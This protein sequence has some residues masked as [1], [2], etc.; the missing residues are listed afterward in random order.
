MG[1]LFK[2]KYGEVEWYLISN[3]AGMIQKLRKNHLKTVVK[4]QIFLKKVISDCKIISWELPDG[5]IVNQSY[6]IKEDVTI[7]TSF[8]KREMF[9]K[10]QF[11]T[12]KINLI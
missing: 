11:Y 12:R 2:E 10:M 3:L 5:F 6:F 4:L 1:Q 7:T 8:N 9:T